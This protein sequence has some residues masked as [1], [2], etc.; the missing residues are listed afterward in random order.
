MGDWCDDPDLSSR[1]VIAPCYDRRV[2]LML[3][4]VWVVV[5]WWGVGG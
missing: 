5:L 1:A 4:L 3:G 2:L